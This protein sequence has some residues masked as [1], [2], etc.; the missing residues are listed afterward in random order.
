MFYGIMLCEYKFKSG[1]S[2]SQ[3]LS[4]PLEPFLPAPVVDGAA[5]TSC[6]RVMPSCCWIAC[7]T[8]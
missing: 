6:R 1:M 3:A 8:S 2:T 4:P 7:V 5:T